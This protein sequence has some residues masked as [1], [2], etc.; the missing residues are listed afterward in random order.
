MVMWF[1]QVLPEII[2]DTAIIVSLPLAALLVFAWHKHAEHK[3]LLVSV[4]RYGLWHGSGER[5]NN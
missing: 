2:Q 3:R 4:V 5:T 1:L